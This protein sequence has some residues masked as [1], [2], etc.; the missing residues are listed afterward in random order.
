[1]IFLSLYAGLPCPF[2]GSYASLPKELSTLRKEIPKPTIELFL[3]ATQIYIA[4]H[5]SD[6]ICISVDLLKHRTVCLHGMILQMKGRP[7]SAMNCKINIPTGDHGPGDPNSGYK[8]LSTTTR[9]AHS[10]PLPNSSAPLPAIPPPTLSMEGVP[11]IFP[12][13]SDS[14]APHQ[15]T[16][17]TPSK[18]LGIC[19]PGTQVEKT[20][21]TPFST[22]VDFCYY[23]FNNT[24]RMILL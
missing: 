12:H 5:S 14:P 21:F 16:S 20:I 22:V 7:C 17:V 13:V 3:S 4:E 15:G 11:L 18:L 1:M 8:K 19:C 24:R 6:D 10:G 23:R 2:A 9:T